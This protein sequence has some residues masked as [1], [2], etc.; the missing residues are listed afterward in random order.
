M[1]TSVQELKIDLSVLP[2][3]MPQTIQIRRETSYNGPFRERTSEEKYWRQAIQ[4]YCVNSN[5]ELEDSG[6]VQLNDYT[7]MCKMIRVLPKHKVLLHAFDQWRHYGS[8][9]F[10]IENYNIRNLTTGNFVQECCEVP[11]DMEDNDLKKDDEYLYSKVL[12]AKLEEYSELNKPEKV[13]E[14]QKIYDELVAARLKEK[15]CDCNLFERLDI[16]DELKRG[17]ISEEEQ[18][19][20]INNL[21]CECKLIKSFDPE[22]TEEQR[23]NFEIRANEEISEMFIVKA[24]QMAEKILK[25]KY[26]NITKEELQQVLDELKNKFVEQQKRQDGPEIKKMFIEIEIE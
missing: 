20:K 21:I 24:I 8:N 4:I 22:P 26:I 5:G 2:Q 16:N 23:E 17:L 7:D 13:K 11:P 9:F 10:K 19:Q 12:L 15:V 25:T 3:I 6:F 1:N 18:V 14:Q